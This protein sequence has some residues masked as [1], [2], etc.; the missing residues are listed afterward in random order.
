MIWGRRFWNEIPI[1]STVILDFKSLLQQ[2]GHSSSGVQSVLSYT[3]VYYKYT[4]F[5]R[6]LTK[7]GWEEKDLHI[8]ACLPHSNST[9]LLK[10]HSIENPRTSPI[11]TG[12]SSCDP[13]SIRMSSSCS[14]T[15]CR[16]YQAPSGLWAHSCLKSTDITMHLHKL[17]CFSAG[18]SAKP[19][20]LVSC[21][22]SEPLITCNC[23]N[24]LRFG[25]SDMPNQDILKLQRHWSPVRLGSFEI[26]GLH[27]KLKYFHTNQAVHSWNFVHVQVRTTQCMKTTKTT[28]LRTLLISLNLW[29]L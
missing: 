11:Y 17:S 8:P 3:L 22:F 4:P 20:K 19:C 6:K 21:L 14:S 27:S 23:S 9:P 13:W 7:C 29:W 26:G 16:I 18:K 24:L 5:H 10:C 1:F 25:I 12:S 28:Q 2:G 15:P